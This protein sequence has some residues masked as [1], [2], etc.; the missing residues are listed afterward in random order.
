[1]LNKPLQVI[2][3]YGIT[4]REFLWLSSMSAAGVLAGCAVNPVT[5]KSQ[6]M[7][8]SE[9]REIQ[10]DKKHSPHQFS[11]D[12]GPLQDNLLNNYI[13]TF[14]SST[15]VS[16]QNMLVNDWWSGDILTR[17]NNYKTGIF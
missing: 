10:I 15:R 16:R 2:T 3:G 13:D 6:L 14:K 4:R 1:M 17:R 9:S 8:V 11:S 12:Y 7:L 5:G